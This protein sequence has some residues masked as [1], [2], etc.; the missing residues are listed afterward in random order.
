[1]AADEE[2]LGPDLCPGRIRPRD[3]HCQQTRF[4][5]VAGRRVDEVM[6]APTLDGPA[7]DPHGR[8]RDR[9]II[10]GDDRQVIGSLGRILHADHPRFPA[11]IDAASDQVAPGLQ[12]ECRRATL[13]QLRRCPAQGETLA[14]PSQ[15]DRPGQA[16][17]VAVDPVDDPITAG[18]GLAGG[19]PAIRRRP[20]RRAA[21]PEAVEVVEDPWVEPAAADPVRSIGRHEG[22]SQADG[23]P[24]DGTRSGRPV[25]RGQL[26]RRAEPRHDLFRDLERAYDRRPGRL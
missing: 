22:L 12:Q 18:A 16:H 23:D 8:C 21:I 4:G 1:M 17:T 9:A 24:G 15:I 10:H 13:L 6:D 19:P 7:M 20:E 14:D 5:R 26:A 25:E 11:G 3:G 2:H